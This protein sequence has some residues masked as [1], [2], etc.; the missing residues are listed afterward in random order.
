MVPEEARRRNNSTVRRTCCRSTPASWFSSVTPCC[1]CP[2]STSSAACPCDDPPSSPLLPPSPLGLRG[3]GGVWDGAGTVPTPPRSRS[4]RAMLTMVRGM[5]RKTDG[6]RDR[7]LAPTPAEDAGLLVSRVREVAEPGPA[8]STRDGEAPTPAVPRRDK[9][10]A[11]AGRGGVWGPPCCALPYSVLLPIM[12][13]GGVV[14][15]RGGGAGCHR[16]GGGGGGRRR[17]PS[18][19]AHPMNIPAASTALVVMRSWTGAITAWAATPRAAS[20]KTP[21][22]NTQQGAAKG[23]H[24]GSGAL[25]RVNKTKGVGTNRPG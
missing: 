17:Y 9:G 23:V 11:L 2:C 6:D 18:T 12:S 8:T 1:P 5:A 25:N 20:C 3:R 14:V 13:R 15:G 16:H 10:P 4:A 7:L 24:V 19:Y 22:A 21:Q